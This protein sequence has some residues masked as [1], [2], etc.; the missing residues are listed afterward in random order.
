MKPLVEAQ[1]AVLAAM[2]PLPSEAVD[3]E[4]ALGLVLAADVVAPHDVPPFANSGMDGFA[5]RAADVASAP[6]TLSVIGDLAA[7]E[8]PTDPVGRGQAIRI[9]TGAPMPAGADAVVMV[10]DTELSGAE[11]RVLAPAAV[12]DH[13]R[14]AG[15]D[16]GAGTT[17]FETGVRLTPFHLGVL[18]SLGLT[19]PVVGRRPTVAILSTGDEVMPP[20]TATLRP[21]A[22]R[23]A[24]RPLLA[25]ALRELGVAVVDLGIVPDDARLLRSVLAEA[26]TS[27]D[28]VLTS[29]GVSMGEHDLVKRVLADIGSIEFWQV[30]MQPARPFAFGFLGITPL[31]GLP[32][33]PVSVSVAFEQFVRPALLHRMG[34]TR[35]FRPRSAATL[36][37]PVSTNPD[38]T[39]FLRVIA[40]PQAGGWAVT[41]VRR[42]ASNMLSGMAGADA[43]AMIPV[44][45]GD[46][47]A[48]DVVAVEWFRSPE[49]R[50][51]EEGLSG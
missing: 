26:A 43:F 18:A 5:V 19:H 4:A 14:P 36:V 24:N 29:G 27:A 50:T 9:M 51:M 41:A 10:E 42:Q 44:G 1:R 13:V 32:G 6:A 8:V 46:V 3:L 17:V 33:N 23:D 49:T 48:G 16:V 37:E 20:E 38:K 15:G 12:G 34:A 47:A 30:A 39:V 35:L 31:F 28:A 2:T 25:A 11:V 7:G 40:R 21:G 45:I 22:I